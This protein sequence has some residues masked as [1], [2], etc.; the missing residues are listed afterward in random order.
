MT[1]NFPRI[2]HEIDIK[3]IKTSLGRSVHCKV[4]EILTTSTRMQLASDGVDFAVK[5]RRVL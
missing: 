3:H 1:A 2:V 5:R 4:R